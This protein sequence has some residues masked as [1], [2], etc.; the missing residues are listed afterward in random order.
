MAIFYEITQSLG[1]LSDFFGEN[2][3]FPK[4]L[5]TLHVRKLLVSVQALNFLTRHIY[6]TESSDFI[7]F[8]YLHNIENT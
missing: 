8:M 6:F 5:H 2:S 7:I 1:E 4:C 3:H